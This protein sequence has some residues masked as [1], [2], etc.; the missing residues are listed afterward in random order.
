[1][2]VSCVRRLGLSAIVTL[3]LARCA[4]VPHE[5]GATGTLDR[6]QAS[7]EVVQSCHEA[8]VRSAEPYGLTLAAT[9]PVGQGATIWPLWVTTVYR[10][11]GGPE[12]RTALINC[13]VED[14]RAVV[15]L[16]N[17]EGG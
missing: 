4:S 6:H 12:K 10:R 3:L 13:H 2:G 15:A 14:G 1:M 8:L 5:P 11:Q 17:G 9:S 7:Q 16:T